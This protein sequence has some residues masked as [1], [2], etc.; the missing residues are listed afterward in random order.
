MNKG[1]FLHSRKW[2]TIQNYT[3]SFGASVVLIGALAKLEHWPM[4]SEFLMVGMSMEALIF[5]ISAFEPLMDNPDW[6]R[7]YPQLREGDELPKVTEVYDQL[8]EKYIKGGAAPGAFAGGGSGGGGAISIKDLPAEQVKK[9]NESFEKLAE[10]ANGIKNLSGATVA[11]D[12]FIKNLQDASQS[13]GLVVESNKKVSGEMEKNVAEIT[14]SYKSAAQNLKSSSEKA[15]SGIDQSVAD[16]TTS[17]KSSADG[18]KS[19]SGKML[20]DIEKSSID[21]NK[22][23]QASAQEL[24]D[25][26]KKITESLSGG[27]KGLEK[28]SATYVDGIDKLNK[29]MAALN[30]AYE[31]HLKGAGKVEEA[32]KHYSGNVAEI[33][34]LLTSSVEETRKFNESTKEISENIQALNKVYG[35]MLGALNTKK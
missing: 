12:S 10:A 26:Y 19:V 34:K 11:T 29:N 35:R 9:L 13:I 24:T 7:V 20:S 18:I 3:Y 21:Y 6:K 22:H 32:V 8:D 4:A 14:N 30:A 28:S 27:F 1:D 16:L 23:L 17:V 2:R 31:L 25:S 5:F 33:G 15:V